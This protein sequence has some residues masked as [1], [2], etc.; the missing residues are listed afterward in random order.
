MFNTPTPIHLL[1]PPPFPL[2]DNAIMCSW[3][4]LSIV[5]VY[6]ITI[7]PLAVLSIHKWRLHCRLLWCFPCRPLIV[8]GSQPIRTHISL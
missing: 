5:A 1:T 4:L 2:A 3:S 8:A 7:R 6:N